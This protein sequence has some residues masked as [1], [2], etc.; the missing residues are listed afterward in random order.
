MSWLT[1][2]GNVL[3][4]HWSRSFRAASGS[5]WIWDQ[6]CPSTHTLV[7]RI[8]AIYFAHTYSATLFPIHFN[9]IHRLINGIAVTPNYYL[10]RK[11]STKALEHFLP[12]FC[13]A[14]FYLLPLSLRLWLLDVELIQC[15]EYWMPL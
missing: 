7:C 12:L 8:K 11:R 13:M 2:P 5:R 3:L 9:L 14:S 1:T 10:W 4:I 15:R 6:C